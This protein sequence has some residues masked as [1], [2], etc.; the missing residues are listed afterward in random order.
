MDYRGMILVWKLES[1]Q[2]FNVWFFKGDVVLRKLIFSHDISSYSNERKFMKKGPFNNM[3]ISILL[4]FAKNNIA[5]GMKNVR[6][7]INLLQGNERNDVGIAFQ[8]FRAYAMM[9]SKEIVAILL[10]RFK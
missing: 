4:F 1:L 6:K 7:W 5:T 9:H 10:K 3:P 2:I 8:L